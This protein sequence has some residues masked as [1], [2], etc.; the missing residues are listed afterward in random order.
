MKAI[1]MVAHPD[2][3][4]IFAYG[5]MHAFPELD[6]TVCY[7]THVVTDHRGSELKAFWDNRGIATKFLGYVD[8]WHD[9][10]NKKISFDEA[11]AWIDIQEAV[12][13]YDIVLTHSESGDYG[14]LH[15]KFVYDAVA[16]Y[17]PNMVT[18]ASNHAGTDKFVIPA[19]TYSFDELPEHKE[20]IAQF[21]QNKHVNEYTIPDKIKVILGLI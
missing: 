6:W 2:D 5:F 14:H 8:D 1:V 20:V 18:F 13:G 3:C 15:H 10:E 21:H 19:G 7:L 4:V 17:H 12:S 9:I 11:R 16:D